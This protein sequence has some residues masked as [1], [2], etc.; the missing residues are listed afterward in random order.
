ALLSLL[1]VWKLSLLEELDFRIEAKRLMQSRYDMDEAGFGLCTP[2]PIK[3]YVHRRVMVTTC[4]PGFKITDDFALS[5]HGVDKESLLC[6]LAH[7]LAYQILVA[8]FF[9]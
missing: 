9:N 5:L 4:L 6:R 1:E 3:G 8:G 7:S 2:V